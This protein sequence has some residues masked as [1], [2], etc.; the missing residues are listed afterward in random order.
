MRIPIAILAILLAA[1]LPV[2][3]VVLCA[4]VALLV[5]VVARRLQRVDVVCDDQPVALL[6]LVFFRAPPSLPIA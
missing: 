4:V 1:V 3:P 6:S 5:F 2:I